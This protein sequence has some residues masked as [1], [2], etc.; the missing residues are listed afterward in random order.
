MAPFYLENTM[1]VKA[2]W[3]FEGDAAKLGT[4]T[5]RIQAEQVLDIEDEELANTL[6]G[7]GLVEK[8]K[9]SANKSAKPNENK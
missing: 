5:G 3:G 1:E 2:L 9:P 8:A 4:E 7:K 6:I